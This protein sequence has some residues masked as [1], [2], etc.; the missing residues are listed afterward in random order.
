MLAFTDDALFNFLTG[1]VCA[2][3]VVFGNTCKDTCQGKRTKARI[4]KDFPDLLVFTFVKNRFLPFE[5]VQVRFFDEFDP[6]VIFF[7]RLEVNVESCVDVT[8][9]EERDAYDGI[10]G[11]ERKRIRGKSF[12][13]FDEV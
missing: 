13:S 2:L 12:G 11:G 3:E 5:T 10:F 8:R 6:H 9:F 1:I 7:R 4:E